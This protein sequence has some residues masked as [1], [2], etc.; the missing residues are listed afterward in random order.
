MLYIE[1][2]PLKIF[3]F[4]LAI[5]V[6]YNNLNAQENVAKKNSFFENLNWSIDILPFVR[7]TSFQNDFGS[8]N[9]NNRIA[10]LNNNDG[11]LYLRPD[12]KL[13]KDKFFIGL[14]PRLNTLFQD[15][16]DTG[17]E[18]YFQ[19]VKL[20]WYINEALYLS[21]GRYIKSIGTST[22]I[23]PSN[24]YFIESGRV[25][26]KIELRPIDFIELNWATNSGWD[27]TLIANLFEG[28]ATNFGFPNFDFY[29]NYGVQTEYYGS[30]INYGGIFSVTENKNYHFGFYAQK[31]LSEA[32][33]MWADGAIKKNV[34][35]FYPVKGHFTNLLSYENVDGDEN[36]NTFFSGLLG[37]SY[38]FSFGPTLY[39][40]Y[41]YNGSGFD[42]ETYDIYNSSISDAS[43][44][45]FG[46]I[47]GLADLNLARSI[48]TGM[49]YIRKHYLFSQLGENDILKGFLNYN[50]RY[51]YSIDDGSSQFSTV[52]E[53]NILDNLELF[54]VSLMNFGKEDSSFKNLIK[55]QLM[56]GAIYRF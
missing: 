34:N 45:N 6:I 46:I 11:G 15:N 14:K 51:F 29:R 17:L 19:E 1:T 10:S 16:N 23:N 56:L 5:L 55:Y 42:N 50:L 38:T 31:N 3:F 20:K 36:E 2:K 49:P 24:P 28:E 37:A 40:E 22:F 35:R 30:S 13:K 8:I 4:L 25:N 43:N 33:V 39:L 26:P 47:K 44:Y 18:F 21:G 12:V 52:I 32:I 7:N 54:N 27:F 9:P 53:A 48:N 41:Y